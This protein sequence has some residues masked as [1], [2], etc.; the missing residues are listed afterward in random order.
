MIWA[1]SVVDDARLHN[2]SGCRPIVS[3]PLGYS[4]VFVQATSLRYLPCTEAE[5]YDL[6]SIKTI[7]GPTLQVWPPGIV[8]DG[9]R[10]VGALTV[11][12]DYCLREHLEYELV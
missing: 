3:I 9:Q 1:C 11:P 10:R 5:N 4:N 2:H 7:Q 6:V 12:Q 8:L